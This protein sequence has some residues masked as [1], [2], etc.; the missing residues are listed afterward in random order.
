[1]TELSNR[2]YTAAQ[3]RELDRR[4]IVEQGIPG[5]VL[6]K[7][8]AR[9]AL[10][11]LL[12]RWPRPARITVFCGGGNNAGDGYIMAGLAAQKGIAV[13]VV[14]LVDESN[15]RGDA[16]EA[17]NFARQQIVAMALFSPALA[18]DGGVVVDALLGIGLAGE[19]RERYQSAI[20]IINAVGLPVLAVDIPSGLCSDTGAELGVA[21][22]ADVTV[23]FIGLKRGLFTG[24]G[25]A[26]CGAVVL[27]D[28]DVPAAVY[29][30]VPAD[31]ERLDLGRLMAQFPARARDAHKGHFGH[32]LVIGGDTGFGGAAAMAAEAAL[33]VGAGLVSVATRPAHVAALLAR[34]PELMVKGVDSG[35]ELEP[36]LSGP[37]VLVVGPG[38]GRSP[39][40]EQLLQ[41]AV[42]SGLP[43]VVDADALN[44]L[45]DGRVAPWGDAGRWIL[46]PHP[47][48]AARLLG[49]GSAEV[50]RDRFAT[51]RA[52]LEKYPGTLVLKGAGSL[53][54]SSGDSLIGLCTAGNPG[55]ATGGMGDVLSGVIGGLLAQGLGAPLAARLGVCLH[56]EA[57]DSVVL[58][59]GERG[60]LATDL[61]ST[62]QRLANKI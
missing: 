50:Q 27:R 40:S 45:A 47:G 25:P 54:V 22:K 20:R 56:A 8:A 5:I 53:I 18:L 59:A 38:L 15:L 3:V 21:V 48:E 44:I 60:L 14:Q 43:M 1:M 30:D 57:A 58:A 4:A 23:S 24:R 34:R 51:S 32:V 11:V 61:L 35:Q 17:W 26:L 28:L 37:S 42:K 16:R 7:R 33:R 36:W 62:I 13:Q 49:I 9:A 46:T 29:Q 6:M 31:V 2:L 39:W 12:A 19:V 10:D 52:L 55:M 41:K